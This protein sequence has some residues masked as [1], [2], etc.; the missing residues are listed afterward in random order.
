MAR[1]KAP[2]RRPN[3]TGGCFQLHKGRKKGQW[4]ARISLPTGKRSE[5]LFATEAEGEDWLHEMREEIRNGTF[6]ENVTQSGT[7][8]EWLHGWIPTTTDLDPAVRDDYAGLIKNHIAP[9]VLKSG[10]MA[11]TSLG[12]VQLGKLDLLQ[13]QEVVTA[14]SAVLSASRVMHIRAVLSGALELAFNAGRIKTDFSKLLKSKKVKRPKVEPLDLEQTQDLREFMAQLDPDAR[15]KWECFFSVSMLAGMR[16]GEVCGLRW[17]DVDLD[18]AVLNVEQNLRFAPSLGH[19]VKPPKSGHARIVRIPPQLVELLRQHKANQKVRPLPG[20]VNQFGDLVFTRGNGQPMS[21]TTVS[22]KFPKLLA[23]AGL[24][25]HRLHDARHSFAT[26]FL[27]S[28]GTIVELRDQLG[29]QDIRTTDIYSH[30][31]PAASRESVDRLGRYLERK[32][33]TR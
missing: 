1:R 10:I 22:K 16:R 32:T 21:L 8:A 13:V 29:H 33:G 26:L 20:A 17:R 12:D 14:K 5:R 28:G 4:L 24:E 7:F 19:Y 11:G 3:R 2:G 25:H 9:Y 23:Q 18:G 6:A 15:L 30:S 27:E 31:T